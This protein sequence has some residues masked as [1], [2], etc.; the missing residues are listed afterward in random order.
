[1]AWSIITL[2]AS[3]FVYFLGG[4]VLAMR[5]AAGS[6]GTT[7]VNGAPIYVPDFTTAGAMSRTAKIPVEFPFAGFVRG[8]T[9]STTVQYPALCFLNPLASIGKGSGTVLRL[10][11]HNGN[12]PTAVAGDI[13]FVKGCGAAFGSGETLINN[14]CTNSGCVSTYTTGTAA[15]NGTDYIKFTPSAALAPGFTARITGSVEDVWGE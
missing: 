12:N 4:L 11:Y 15:F 13:G 8:G 3:K 9:G 7:G 2:T 10:K 5:I 1:M 6:G 14:T